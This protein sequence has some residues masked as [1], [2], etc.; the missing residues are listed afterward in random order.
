M[1]CPHSLAGL[2]SWRIWYPWCVPGYL[3]TP[4]LTG[5]FQVIWPNLWSLVY[6]RLCDHTCDHWCVPGYVATPV[7]TWCVPGYVATPVITGQAQSQLV[8]ALW[9]AR[10]GLV[11]TCSS[12]DRWRVWTNERLGRLR[13]DQCEA[14]LT[15]GRSAGQNTEAWGAGAWRLGDKTL[16]PPSH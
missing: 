7:I 13:S 3:N 12:A 6:A 5:V 2:I 4:M 9:A 16:S 10:P 8:P 11:S 1:L 14:R 15:A